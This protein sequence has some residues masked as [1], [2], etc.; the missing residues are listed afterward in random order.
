MLKEFRHHGVGRQTEGGQLGSLLAGT[1]GGPQRSKRLAAGRSRQI[2]T[3]ITYLSCLRISESGTKSELLALRFW[4]QFLEKGYQIV[5]A[6]SKE[7]AAR[8]LPITT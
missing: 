6:S 4:P 8:G 7:Q 5:S 2:S 1:H 3:D